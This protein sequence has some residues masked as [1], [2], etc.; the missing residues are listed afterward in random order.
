MDEVWRAESP[1]SRQETDIS[2]IDQHCTRESMWSG[3]LPSCGACRNLIPKNYLMQEYSELDWRIQLGL[4]RSRQ[5]DHR[6]SSKNL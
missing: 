4:R 3:L 5:L 6:S 1:I 2:K